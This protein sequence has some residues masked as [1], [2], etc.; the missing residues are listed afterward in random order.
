MS[1]NTNTVTV[2]V[3]LEKVADG[4]VNY[5]DTMQE[6]QIAEM[7]GDND[8]AFTKCKEVITIMAHLLEE[9]IGTD[10]VVKVNNIASDRAIAR[11]QAEEAAASEG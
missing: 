1:E 11:A 9:V 2:T 6:G 7:F 8:A 10:N 5:Y 4:V 3:D